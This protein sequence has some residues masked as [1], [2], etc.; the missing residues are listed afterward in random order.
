MNWRTPFF[1]R[2]ILPQYFFEYFGIDKHAE[3]SSKFQLI[4][5]FKITF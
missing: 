5:I 3:I 1:I 4:K 2:V